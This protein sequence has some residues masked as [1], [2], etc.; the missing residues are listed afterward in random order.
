M[1]RTVA[2]ITMLGWAGS[3]FAIDVTYS[4]RNPT[5][6][7]VITIEI[8]GCSQPGVIHWG[9]N[10]E[11]TRWK[12]ALPQYRPEGSVMDGVATRSA[13]EGPDEHGVC[14]I[15][16]GPFTSEDQQVH[17]LNFALQ[18]KD[19]SWSNKD[20]KN[21]NI[22]VSLGRIT[23]QPREPT[24][25][26]RI[27]V[28][29]HDSPGKGELRWGVNAEGELWK[30]PHTNYWPR[31]TIPAD[32]GIAVDTPF[33]KPEKGEASTVIL[34]PFNR[35][36]QVVK[37]LHM[38]V[39]WG[40]EWDTDMS[41]NYNTTIAMNS[42]ADSPSVTFVSPSNGEVVVE[43]PQVV[44]AADHSEAVDMW[45]NGRPVATIRE[46]PFEL[47]IPFQQLKYGRHV[48][49][50]RGARGGDVGMQEI[51]F[52]RVPP[53]VNE[54]IPPDTAWGTTVHDD[55]TVTFTLHAPGKL[56][57]SLVGS[58]NEW[59]PFA[60]MMKSSPDGTWWIRRPVP[61]G[62]HEYQ[63]C[64]EGRNYIADPYARDIEW[65]DKRGR[66]GHRPEDA[67]AVVRVD[68]APFNWK[69][70]DFQRPPLDNLLVYEFH[71]DDFAPGQGYTGVI[72]KLDYIKDLGFTAIQPMPFT[73]FPVDKSWGYNPAF[74]FAPESTYGTPDDL[75]RLVDETHKRGM[76]F[77]VDLVMNHMDRNGALYQLYGRD[78]EG[79]PFF[80]QF[81]G[82]NWGFPDLEQTSRA[83]K[84][85]AADVVQ[86]WTRE[87]HA[88]GI[89]Y[90]A[91][92]FVEWSGYNDWGGG[93]LAYAAKQADPNSFQI[94]EHMPSDPE[95]INVTEMDTTW[96]DSF[97]WR[98]R[99]MVENAFLDRGTFERMLMPTLEGY[100]NPVQRMAYT[101][102][103]DEERVMHE[104]MKRGYSRDEAFRRCSLAL[105]L[106]LTV[107]GC[108]MVY[109]GQEFAEDTPKV[110]GPNPLSFQKLKR[111]A[112][113][114]F[115]QDA[116]ALLRLRTS[117]PALSQGSVTIQTHGVPDQVAAYS[118][119]KDDHA[120]VVIA[121]F[122]KVRQSATLEFP[123]AGTWHSVL[124]ARDIPLGA[125]TSMVAR[126][127]PGEV[128]VYTG[129]AK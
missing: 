41:R 48:L 104:L 113:Q 84:R 126:L 60:D 123:F 56:F 116:R 39:H 88:D 101:E 81:Q 26:D 14:R 125:A 17:S 50:A 119:R 27:V 65:K 99:E 12:E 22:E 1:I 96:H 112:N 86:Y 69:T 25:N 98:M 82:E 85:Y 35:A 18:W 3:I 42:G 80:R 53:H 49:T 37:T 77:L 40:K 100:T 111:S 59:N 102:S 13:L 129:V 122:G 67:R 73:E 29:I 106:T 2:F 114:A 105:A 30:P 4:P 23:W 120:V 108:A 11:G 128:L 47:R 109:S 70:R 36:E 110:V 68:Q 62:V 16:L 103:H 63:F 79:S 118:R 7:D 19:G 43:S 74:H 64:I 51:A 107:P 58:F 52:W 6:R 55:G 121:N 89:R 75:K 97:R 72:A 87:Y 115:F 54:S 5:L 92:R 31:G 20:E 90:D 15:R 76:A 45:L 71:I 24:V 124:E 9:V 33:A 78:Y 93:W 61:K 32:D 38:A 21:F 91:T 94:A 66:E 57:V 46:A 8:Q 28:T 83:F 117:N 95:F 127:E 10:A 44:L 34:G